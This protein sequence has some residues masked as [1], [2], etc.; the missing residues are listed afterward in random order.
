[1]NQVEVVELNLLVSETIVDRHRSPREHP[2]H[3]K[4]RCLSSL[5]GLKLH[6]MTF[7]R[8]VNLE[9]DR[10][11]SSTDLGCGRWFSM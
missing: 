3:W 9:E 11:S 7:L 5:G 2:D 10:D 6:P 8:L 1:M 4:S